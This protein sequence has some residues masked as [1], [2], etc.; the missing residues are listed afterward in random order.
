MTH[1]SPV[2]DPQPYKVRAEL[3]DTLKPL[4]AKVLATSLRSWD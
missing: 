2:Q 1:I 4:P 3:L